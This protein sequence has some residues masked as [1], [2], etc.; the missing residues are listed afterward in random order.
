MDSMS[1]RMAKLQTKQSA[2]ET[3]HD[4]IDASDLTLS[5]GVGQD[6]PTTQVAHST[7]EEM[8][9]NCT[10]NHTNENIPPRA[11]G[12]SGPSNV[13]GVEKSTEHG[14]GTEGLNGTVPSSER[15][16]PIKFD[17][18]PSVQTPTNEIAHTELK[19][20]IPNGDGHHH[21]TVTG[22]ITDG[23]GNNAPLVMKKM[24]LIQN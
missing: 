11:N 22:K 20:S 15:S 4:K 16:L 19:E 12:I 5:N 2:R 21:G 3:T 1:K 10:V 8:I 9:P 24:D 14:A 18:L 13:N 7:L 17:D 6:P 23:G